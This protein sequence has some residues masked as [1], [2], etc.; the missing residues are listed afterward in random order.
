MLSISLFLFM[1]AS[2]TSALI[3]SCDKGKCG[4]VDQSG[5]RVISFSYDAARPF[6][7]DTAIVRKGGLWGIIDKNGKF[8][9]KPQFIEIK[10]CFQD[11][12][13][14]RKKNLWG[15]IDFRGKPLSSFEFEEALA[16]KE[17]LAPVKTKNGWAI[18]NL[19]N[20]K[21]KYVLCQEIMPFSNGLARIKK[22]GKYGYINSKGE[23]VLPA[24]YEKAFDF[25]DGFAT[26]AV[27]CEWGFISAETLTFK[28]KDFES[29]GPYSYGL[30]PA[31]A[32]I[33]GKMNCGYI[34][35]KGE[36]KINFDYAMCAHFR[37]NLAPVL[38]SMKGKWG[39]INR[40][41]KQVS[42]FKYDSIYGF[43][44]GLYLAIEA[45]KSFY[46][47]DNGKEYPYLHVK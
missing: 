25:D 16:A 45:N 40:Q 44:S 41:G 8:T 47:D 36:V 23:E 26:A 10:E 28:K 13:A 2:S 43:Y 21:L 38:K 37:G 29:L 30:A 14:A 33:D 27:D 24:V 39:F 19:K 20:G 32:Q 18:L 46:I 11:I 12:C 31:Y 42:A 1:A 3:P 15:Y 34:D 7:K 6:S 22:D 5:K 35:S 9:A 4:Y 17:S